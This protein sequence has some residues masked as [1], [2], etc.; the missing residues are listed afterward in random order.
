MKDWHYIKG[1]IA[2]KDKRSSL[3]VKN[4][5]ASVIIKG[6]SALVQFLLVPITLACL[7]VYENGVWLTI[8]SVLLWIDNLDIGLGNGLR[9]KLA[10]Y[11]ARNDYGKAREMVSS[12]FAMLALIIIP[13][14][15][16][17][18]GIETVADNYSLFNVDQARV[19]DL[20]TILIITTLLVCTTFIFKF[21]G[22]F[23]MGL[24]LPAIN[25][26]LVT[27]GNTV[28]L[29]GTLLVYLFG[30][31]SLMSIALVYTLSPLLVYML[32]YPITFWRRYSHLRPSWNFVTA[33]AIKEL[34]ST[35]VNFFIL[36]ISGVF[37]FFSSNIII[38]KLFSPSMVTPY[39]IAHRYFTIALLIF[40]II[41]VPYWTATTDAY[42]KKDFKWI[43]HANKV[44]NR[45]IIGIF[46]LIVIM[47]LLSDFAYSI[48]I[49]G[50]ATIPFSI[51]VLG[52]LYQFILIWST[53]YSFVL[54][55]FGALRL[56]MIC[57]IIAA[58]S[59]IP[60]AVF[61]GKTTGNINYLL[62]TMCAVNLPGLII[63]AIQYRK[64]ISGKAFGIW[65][66]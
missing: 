28:T 48:W 11:I 21:I 38:S 12:T 55:G 22:N 50:Q 23:Y 7:G 8:S 41:C 63:N 5:L 39:Q 1:I 46:F 6:W 18:V 4:V 43:E 3:I 44:L 10:T 30:D 54:N 60:L 25:N 45:L 31:H 51:T 66:K 59:Y 19:H 33:S 57:T 47:I 24:Q 42:E 14:A 40:T 36:Q 9:N 17:L 56:Q 20:D 15:L 26:F 27:S 34:L 58:I 32:C 35:G 62:I 16:I 52:G 64:I 13:T 2:A 29:I 61:V 65:I 49:Q 37:L 53:R